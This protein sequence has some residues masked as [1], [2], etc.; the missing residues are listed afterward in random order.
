MNNL[1]MFQRTAFVDGMVHH[2]LL[3]CPKS[4]FHRN[5]WKIGER[6]FQLGSLS[7][8]SVVVGSKFVVIVYWYR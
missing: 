4:A 8:S 5:H 2:K 6:S 7:N 3:K 1:K